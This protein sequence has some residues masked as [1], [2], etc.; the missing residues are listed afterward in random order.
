MGRK[1][2]TYIRKATRAGKRSLYIN[3]P[4]DIVRELKIRERQKLVVKRVG[5]R[6]SIEDW[7]PKKKKK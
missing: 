6:I 7:K 5:K 3:I 1:A 2:K 4:A